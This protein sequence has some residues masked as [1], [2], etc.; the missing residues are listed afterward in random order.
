MVFHNINSVG[1]LLCLPWVSWLAPR[2]KE[3]NFWQFWN[4]MGQQ[5]F[6]WTL[7]GTP[8]VIEN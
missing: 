5:N 8:T 1:L 2:L 4:N 3:G 6:M 7:K